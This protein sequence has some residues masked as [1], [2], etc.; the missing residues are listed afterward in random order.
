[1]NTQPSPSFIDIIQ[2]YYC[3]KDFSEKSV[4]VQKATIVFESSDIN[5][6]IENQF[7]AYI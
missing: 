7:D 6:Q 5:I 1:M 3:I 2:P 4:I